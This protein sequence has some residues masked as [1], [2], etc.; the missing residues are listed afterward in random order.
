[1]P[2]RNYLGKIY[3]QLNQSIALS[4]LRWKQ[5]MD[6]VERDSFLPTTV[7]WR[8]CSGS[9]IKYRGYPCSLWTL[10]HVLTVSQIEMENKK[11]VPCKFCFSLKFTFLMLNSII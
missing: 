7:D 9:Q 3:S 5:L 8:H 2:V 6:T 1:M 10:F 11:Q 4:G